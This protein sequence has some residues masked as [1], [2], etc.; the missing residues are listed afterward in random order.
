[1]GAFFVALQPSGSKSKSVKKGKSSAKRKSVSRQS[2]DNAPAP[3]KDADVIGVKLID[4]EKKIANNP[5]PLNDFD[6]KDDLL[7]RERLAEREKLSESS[8]WGHFFIKNSA[9]SYFVMSLCG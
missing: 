7:Q 2:K 6:S 1:L 9:G 4:E 3:L 8:R 5:I